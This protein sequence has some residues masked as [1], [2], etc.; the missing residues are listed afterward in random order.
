[1]IRQDDLVQWLIDNGG[2]VIRYRTA[3]EL[4][5]GYSVS[6]LEE[7]GR[8]LLQS[9][10]VQYWLSCLSGKTG[11]NDIHG[12]RDK[13][14]ENAMGKLTLFGLR[15]G[16]ADFDLRCKTYLNL[17][18]GL[19]K[20]WSVIEVLSRTIVASLLAM[21]GYLTETKVRGW[22]EER[23]DTVYGFVK[24]G[25]YSIY[26][27]KFEFK[28]IPAAFKNHPL[29]N[30]DLY[31][32][33]KFALPWIY[34]IFAFS[35]LHNQTKEQGIRAKIASVISYILDTRYQQLH[36]G[37]GIVL[38]G[39]NH[40][41][42]MGW[43]VWLPGY[44]RMHANSF[45]MGCLIQRLELMSRFPDV[46]SNQWFTNNLDHL[47]SF[48]TDNRGYIFPKQYIQERKNSYFVTGAHMGLGENR[49]NKLA[50]KVESTFWMLK[51]MNNVV[52]VSERA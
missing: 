27:D 1:M 13:C 29:I 33:G 20:E 22:I 48:K 50:Y 38:T 7:M 9:E 47:G 26:V 18:T 36:D 39:K 31:A 34:D 51:I 40:Y 19:D 2:E 16:M 44:K 24:K 32:H 49:R 4:T 28:N 25:L 6:T 23:L 15:K 11:F 42:V 43:N 17:I 12:R 30:P 14:F 52:G 8:D 41:N 21:G 46:L 3:S 5:K 35:V 45:S 37:Y 10:L